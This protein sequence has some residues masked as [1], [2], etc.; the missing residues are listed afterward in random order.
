MKT[1]FNAIK[2][3]P[4]GVVESDKK[5]GWGGKTCESC[6]GPGSRHAESGTAEE[7]RNPAK[8]GPGEVD[9][10]CLKCHLNQPTHVGR[11]QSSH[12]KSQIACTGCH[13]IHSHGPNGLVVRK[14]AS[15]SLT[16]SWNLRLGGQAA[17]SRKSCF[18]MGNS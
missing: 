9:K 18:A 8:L 10:T 6:H 5:R 17:D 14:P 15:C 16:T 13:S 1:S 2:A 3:S 4:H 12:A 11:I 7:I